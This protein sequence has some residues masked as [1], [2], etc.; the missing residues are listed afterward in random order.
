MEKESRSKRAQDQEDVTQPRLRLYKV[1][2]IN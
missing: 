1:F 2:Q